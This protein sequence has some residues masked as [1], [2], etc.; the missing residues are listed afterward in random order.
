M[1]P[2]VKG[3]RATPEPLIKP[4]FERAPATFA[5]IYASVRQAQF[6][7]VLP[8]D[9]RRLGVD[10]LR[11]LDRLCASRIQ[12]YLRLEREQREKGRGFELPPGVPDV[13]FGPAADEYKRFRGGMLAEALH[14]AERRLKA[15]GLVEPWAQ[16]IT[17]KFG[18]RDIGRAVLHSLPVASAIVTAE[19]AGKHWEIPEPGILRFGYLDRSQVRQLE[20][21]AL[22]AGIESEGARLHMSR[23][24]I[25]VIKQHESLVPQKLADALLWAN[26]DGEDETASLSKLTESINTDICQ[27]VQYVKKA[28]VGSNPFKKT[29]HQSNLIWEWMRER[30]ADATSVYGAYA[31][32]LGTSDGTISHSV[33]PVEDEA[34]R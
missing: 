22:P 27:G 12:L 6:E 10:E 34:D 4:G 18:K 32:W 14:L 26:I 31:E 13:V 8:G 7:T 28:L 19:L 20:D 21:E 33:K 16:F 1:R 3:V 9:L 2:K 17:E 30:A 24:I 5:E 15:P 11:T 23:R 29:V 25:A